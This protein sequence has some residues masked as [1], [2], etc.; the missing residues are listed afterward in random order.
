MRDEFKY[1][2]QHLEDWE[3]K[4]LSALKAYLQQHPFVRE[5]I[6]ETLYLFAEASHGVSQ[7]EMDK[8]NQIEKSLETGYRLSRRNSPKK[9]SAGIP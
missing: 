8:I 9:N 7:E 1:L 3:S 6:S 4:F 5:F 2:L